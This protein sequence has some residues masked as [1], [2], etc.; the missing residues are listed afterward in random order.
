MEPIYA[1][2]VLWAVLLFLSCIGYGAAI[3][4][5]LNLAEFNNF[6]WATKAAVGMS[7][8]I[9]LGSALMVFKAATPAGLT[10]VAVVGFGLAC[11]FFYLELNKT[12][13]STSNKRKSRPPVAKKANYAWLFLVIPAAFAL[14]TFA[15]SI[16]W[17][18]QYD[19]N[20]DWIAY[21][22]FPEKILQTGTLIEPFSQ[23]RI[24]SLCGQSILL[25]QIMIVAEPESAHLLDRGLGAILLFGL[26]VEA[27]RKTAPGW[28]WLRALFILVAV[29]VSVPRINTS[30]TVIGV[31]LM[32]GTFF[33]MRKILETKDRGWKIW[34]LPALI[35][36]GASSLRFTYAVTC[37]GALAIFYF[38]S[39][40]S[41]PPKEWISRILPL[42][43][44]GIIT[45]VFLSPLMI[46]SWESSG[47]PIYPP[48]PGNLVTEFMT[49]NTG[50]GFFADSLIAFQWLAM[51][52]LLVMLLSFPLVF[53]LK[54]SMQR[55][56]FSLFF[57]FIS[58]S[59]LIGINSSASAATSNFDF[60][61]FCFPMFF[62]AFLW[63]LSD[64]FSQRQETVFFGPCTLAGLALAIFSIVQF[65]PAIEEL[66][67]KFA[68]LP[69]QERGFR[70]S[71]SA[72]KPYYEE[73]QNKVPTGQKIFAV[74]D[75]PYLLDYKRNPLSNVDNIASASPPPGMPFKKGSDALKF[76]LKN[77]DYKYIIA[78]DFDKAVFLYNRKVMKNHPREE[79]REFSKNYITDFLENIES[80]AKSNTIYKNDNSRLISIGASN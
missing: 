6:G 23:R 9:V 12:Q 14:L 56:L 8:T 43:K 24:T 77:L 79:F 18:F 80:L 32:F 76:Y 66:K 63:V 31:C 2:V 20:D 15:T 61:R 52:E 37:G 44:T 39:A 58:I 13:I 70:F 33:S 47:T 42:F 69:S 60:Y 16:Y 35:L 7:A 5:L 29:T 40:L 34:V 28:Q 1:S 36:A 74:V 71:A 73:L 46:V 49:F 64:N 45:F 17:P 50:K 54:A 3:V 55:V 48:F 30:S 19:P 78:V 41:S 27:T 59:Y 25:A 53:F 10:S 51:P 4:R 57:I 38:W 67:A 62:T 72:L 21:L 22:A 75:A 65:V 26:L 11:Y 68:V